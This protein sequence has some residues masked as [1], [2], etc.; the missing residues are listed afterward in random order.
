MDYG[1]SGYP[2]GVPF[3][4]EDSK[5]VPMP[6][7]V[8]KLGDSEINKYGLP[9]FNTENVTHQCHITFST[10]RNHI[11]MK[12]G[13]A[14]E[15]IAPYVHKQWP[16]D[17]AELF[18]ILTLVNESIWKWVISMTH[19]SGSTPELGTIIQLLLRMDITL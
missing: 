2:V 14:A 5:M 17:K 13:Q 11:L 19:I 1:M 9:K 16:N 10:A 12:A 8:T 6:D 15:L 7:Y 3:M 18:S 4:Q